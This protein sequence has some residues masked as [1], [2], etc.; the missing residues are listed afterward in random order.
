MT[1]IVHVLYL[2]FLFIL[3]LTGCTPLHWAAIRG[4]LEACTVL[5]QAG[6]KEDLAVTDSS[7][8]TPAQL[9][10]EKGHRHIALFLVCV[11]YLTEG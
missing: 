6:T 1:F 5:V 9:A 10:S 11:E 7:G 8:S 4:N 2:I 3:K